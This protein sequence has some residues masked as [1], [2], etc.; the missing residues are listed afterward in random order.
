VFQIKRYTLYYSYLCISYLLIKLFV[1]V[2]V[3]DMHASSSVDY[4]VDWRHA[5]AALLDELRSSLGA[6]AHTQYEREVLAVARARRVPVDEVRADVASM[7]SAWLLLRVRTNACGRFVRRRQRPSQT[8][9]N[10]ENWRWRLEA[11]DTAQRQLYVTIT[12]AHS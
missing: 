8:T 9:N 4:N 5:Q 6:R 7:S 10:C 2:F 12:N 3:Q 11:V 1:H